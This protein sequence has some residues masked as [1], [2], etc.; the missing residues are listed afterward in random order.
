[1]FSMPMGPGRASVSSPSFGMLQAGRYPARTASGTPGRVAHILYDVWLD[2]CPEERPDGRAGVD[3][4]DG[5]ADQHRHGQHA[6][7]RE[8]ALLLAQAHRVGRDELDDRARSEPIDGRAGEDRVDAA[9][10]N[11]LGA[12]LL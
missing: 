8:G 4:A 5:L 7:V 11:P 9:R 1:M 2:R 3:P 6:Q 12:L 10:V